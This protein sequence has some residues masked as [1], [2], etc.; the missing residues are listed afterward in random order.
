[1]IALGSPNARF[2]P[3]YVEDVARVFTESLTR[4]DSFGRSYDVAG[5]KAYTLRELVACVGEV[6]GHRRRI[7]GL[8]DTLSY[9]QARVMELLPGKLITRDN[10][11]FDEGRQRVFERPA[12]R[13]HAYAR[14]KRSRRRGSCSARLATATTPSAPAPVKSNSES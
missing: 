10:L 1:M 3:V 7:I 6:T 4:L 13:H 9:L 14:S 8:D 5:P 2:Q 11:L 12:F